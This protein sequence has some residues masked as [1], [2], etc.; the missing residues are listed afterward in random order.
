MKTLVGLLLAV[1]ASCAWASDYDDCI[2]ENMKGVGSQLGAA[3]VRQA[4]HNKYAPPPEPIPAK[5]WEKIIDPFDQSGSFVPNAVADERCVI[6][7]RN[8]SA[9]SRHFGECKP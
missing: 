9:W 7:C 2:L 3:A 8:A 4:C 6:E 5:C 1:V